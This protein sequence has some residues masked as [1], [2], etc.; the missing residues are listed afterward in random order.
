MRMDAKDDFAGAKRT[1]DAKVAA[2]SSFNNGGRERMIR[3]RQCI[4][5]FLIT[6]SLVV[7]NE[8]MA[9]K[10]RPHGTTTENKVRYLEQSRWS[11]LIDSAAVLITGHF[12]SAVHEEITHRIWG[13]EGASADACVKPLPY[14]RYAPKSIIFGVQWNDNPPFA[15][16][17]TNTNDCPVNTTIRLPNYSKCWVTLFEDARKR[18]EKG[19]HFDH[20]SDVALLYR[21]HFGDMQFLHAMASWDGEKMEDTKARIMMWAQLAYSTAV[22]EIKP[23]KAISAVEV[24]G[25]SR[26]FK[27]KGYSVESLFT[28]GVPE[29]RPYVGQVAMGSLMHVIQDSFAK[30][31]VSRE[32][33]TGEYCA[34][35]P[36][37]KRAGRVLEFHSF[38]QQDQ[39]KHGEADSREA[40]EAH[41]ISQ[42]PNVVAVGRA[43]KYMYDD[44]SPWVKVS[45]FLS[46]CVFEIGED[47]LDRP[48][49]P[50]DNFTRD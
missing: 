50:G 15:L 5:L 18:A 29:H 1:V 33:P 32:E 3:L 27:G 35:Y 40:F 11:N 26:L 30:G 12:T 47:D 22:G 41:F 36:K 10:L 43:L 20:R 17:S 37:V 38:S 16:T 9:F 39:E 19:T 6:F 49:G 48:A 8:A 46:Q 31:H 13:C 7:A 28:R 25:I 14:G 44:K 45:A 42:D 2:S 23:D 34:A 21:V 4:P 24:K